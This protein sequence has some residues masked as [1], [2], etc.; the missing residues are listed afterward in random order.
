[1]SEAIQPRNRGRFSN[2]L[3]ALASHPFTAAACI[4]ILYNAIRFMQIT[5][6]SE[7]NDVYVLAAARLRAGLDIYLLVPGNQDHAYSYPPFQALLAIPFTFLPRFAAQFAWLLINILCLI[8]FWR[9]TWR[10][11]GGK[12]IEQS[13]DGK[14]KGELKGTVPFNSRKSEIFICI[15]GLLCGMRFVQEC[16]DHQQ[17]DLFIGVL[18][19]GGCLA[20]QRGRDWLAAGC[21][22]LAAAMKGPPLLFAAYLLWRGRWAAALLMVALAVGVNLL[23]D[24]VSHAP[25]GIWLSQWYVEIIRPVS[26]VGAWHS[27]VLFNQSLAGAARRYFAG[28]PS[29]HALRFSVYGI[30][31][32]LLAI[33]ALWM[34][35]PFRRQIDSFRAAL[36]CSTVILLMLLL[37]PMSSKPHFCVMLLPAYCL[38]RLAVANKKIVAMLAVAIC[39]ALADLLDRNF[40][41]LLGNTIDRDFLAWATGDRPLWYGSVMWAAVVLWIGCI[42][43]GRTAE[44]REAGPV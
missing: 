1:V 44:E 33:T 42:A 37:S 24:L 11:S 40:L 43:A 38:A 20:W 10:I 12:K 13:S 9:W 27:D 30:E 25:R 7:W 28:V 14:L 6:F 35:K 32:L 41:R 19:I 4:Y 39:I 15:L 8:L 34:G 26:Q 16:F 21:W 5:K 36:E 29:P 17:T 23:P 3:Q 31:V 18:V 2:F 22:G